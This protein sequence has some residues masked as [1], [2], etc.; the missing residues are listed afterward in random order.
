MAATEI[1]PSKDIR[2]ESN[3]DQITRIYNVDTGDPD[4]AIVQGP[5]E[6]AL[7]P[8]TSY[9]R[10]STKHVKPI[11]GNMC[12]LRVVYE[13]HPEL[14]MSPGDAGLAFFDSTA[15]TEHIVFDRNGVLISSDEGLPE[16]VDVYRPQ[17]VHSE[18][19][20]FTTV[21]NAYVETLYT[22]TATINKYPWKL[23]PARSMIFL[24]AT[25]RREGIEK[26]RVDYRFMYRPTQPIY[27]ENGNIIG[28]AGGWDYVWNKWKK[29]P[30]FNADLTTSLKLKILETN[31]SP[32]YPD[33][34]F[35][36]L[37]IGF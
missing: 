24:G 2:E 10:V 34:R 25:G 4:A 6:G 18:T 19:W 11:A 7:Y 17:F 27:D 16:G 12:E 36:N 26:W 22:Y 32:V 37:G 14:P 30:G 29:E 31:V 23:W 5:V 20:W 9:T 35:V 28:T 13:R 3:R 8:G 21:T 1:V 33:T 15:Q